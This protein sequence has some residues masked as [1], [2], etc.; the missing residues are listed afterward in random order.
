[1][2]KISKET[3]LDLY[4]DFLK[5]YVFLKNINDS[6]FNYPEEKINFHIYSEIKT[7]KELQS[8]KSYFATQNLKKTNLIIWSDYSI[9]HLECLAPFKNHITFKIYNPLEEAKGTILEGKNEVLLAHDSKYYLRSDLLRLLALHKYGG[10]WIDMDVILLRDFKP[11]LDQEFMYQW[12]DITDFENFG[13]CGT[14]LSLKK[15]SELS[16]LLLKELLLMPILPGTTVW[17]KDLFAIIYKNYYKFDIFP[18]SFFNIEWM[19]P[20][21]HDCDGVCCW[22]FK[23]ACP[24][25]FLFLGCFAWHWH[26]TGHK[27]RE[28]KNNSKFDKLMKI[29]E[30]KIKIK[31][32]NKEL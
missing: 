29:N 11:I 10:I 32:L 6:E 23:D 17:G 5:S 1:M 26:N 15:N 28:I 18:S 27:N 19:M 21:A 12:G 24:D 9:E 8:V 22:W 7:E 4:K 2:I 16:N 3:H 30:E 13:P 31:L 14:V 25:E 20:V